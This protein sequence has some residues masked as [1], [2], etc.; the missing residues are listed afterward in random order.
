MD[1]QYSNT[2]GADFHF[3]PNIIRQYDGGS[4]LQIFHLNCENRRVSPWKYT[5]VESGTSVSEGVDISGPY[6]R[7]GSGTARATEKSASGG[8]ILRGGTSLEHSP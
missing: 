5:I 4:T 3:M 1:V 7:I 2:N 6:C 8:G